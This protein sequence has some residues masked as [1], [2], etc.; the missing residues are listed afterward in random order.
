MQEL[1]EFFPQY[2]AQFAPNTAEALE[3]FMRE[4]PFQGRVPAFLGDDRTDEDGFDFVNAH[5]G[6]SV[7][8]GSGPTCA[9]RNLPDPLAVWRV[10]RALHPRTALE[11]LR[12]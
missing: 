1:F 3:Q 8:V 2:K 10:L 4:P 12:A 7:H 11:H 5:G 6:W 9:R